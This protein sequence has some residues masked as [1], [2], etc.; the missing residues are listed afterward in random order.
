MFEKSLKM[1]QKGFLRKTFL[2]HYV[3]S[4]KGSKDLFI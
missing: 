4:I 3:Y 1:L 2:I